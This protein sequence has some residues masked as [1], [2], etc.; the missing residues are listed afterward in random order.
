MRRLRDEVGESVHLYVRDEDT[1]ICIAAVEARHELRPFIQ[2][3]RPLPLRAGAAGKVLLAFA[4]EDIQR[5]ELQRAEDDVERLP[6]APGPDLARQLERRPRRT[7]GDLDRRTRERRGCRRDDGDGLDRSRRGRALHLRADDASH[8][9]SASRTCAHPSRPAAAE[10]TQR[11]CA[12]ADGGSVEAEQP[13]Q[14]QGDGRHVG[15]EQQADQQRR[16]VVA[17]PRG[18]RARAGSPSPS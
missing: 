1:R 18:T 7:L 11:S 3:G 9:A 16:E 6:N 2:L 14:P 15:D 4:D 12:G 17:A 10:V 5:Q 13:R 8:D